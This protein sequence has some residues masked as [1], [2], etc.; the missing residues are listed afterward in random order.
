MRSIK[1]VLVMAFAMSYGQ[2]FGSDLEVSRSEFGDTWPFTVESGV[3][4]CVDGQ[5]AIFKSGG[6]SYQLNGFARSRG[7]APIDPIW[8]D[9]PDIPGTKVSIGEMIRIALERC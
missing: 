2:A 5:A 3:V 4:A 6:K 1:L 8:R 7:Y 9:N